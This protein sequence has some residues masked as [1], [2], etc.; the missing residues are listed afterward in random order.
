M[1]VPNMLGRLR[2]NLGKSGFL[3][4]NPKPDDRRCNIILES[5]VLKYKSSFEYLGVVISD[6]GVLKNDVQ[7]FVIQK[8]AN[9]STKFSNFCKVNRNAPLSVKLEVLDICVAS[10]ITYACE[11]WGNNVNASEVCYRGGLK[12]AMNIRDNI[13]NEIVYIESGKYPLACRIKKAQLK[14]WSHVT[15]YVQEFPEAALSKMVAIGLDSN[16]TYLK[17]YRALQDFSDPLSCENLM[18]STFFEKWKQKISSIAETDV[19]SRLGTYFRINQSLE[20]YVPQPQN[21]MEIERILVTRFRTGS[22]SL[23]IELGRYSN[24]APLNRTCVCGDVQSVWHIFMECPLTVLCC[25][26][27]YNDLSD[28]FAD[29]NVHKYLLSISKVLKFQI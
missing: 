11:T 2:V 8:R 26:R 6:S 18:K 20:K 7:A 25:P 28:I 27:D 23:A 24:I 13:N 10:A 12:V 5:G 9:V 19:D 21:I 22:H 1:Y 29:E 14:F 17:Y 4:I 3:I 15:K 16:I